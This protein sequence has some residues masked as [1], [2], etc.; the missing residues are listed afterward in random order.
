[1]Q[2]PLLLLPLPLVA[3][4]LMLLLWRTWMMWQQ[5]AA[6]LFQVSHRRLVCQ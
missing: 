2:Q 1:V 3:L 5:H 6:S 4:M